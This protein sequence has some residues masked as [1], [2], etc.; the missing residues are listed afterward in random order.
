MGLFLYGR[1]WGEL[2]SFRD[3]GRFL[4]GGSGEKELMACQQQ[5]Y[6]PSRMALIQG[7]GNKQ[8]AQPL[9]LGTAKGRRMGQSGGRAVS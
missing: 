2:F 1:Q 7:E 4:P 3:G 8:I 5:Q 6:Q 9:G